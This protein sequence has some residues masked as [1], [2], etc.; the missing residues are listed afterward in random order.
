MKQMKFQNMK[1][2]ILMNKSGNSLMKKVNYQQLHKKQE[3]VQ[4]KVRSIIQFTRQKSIVKHKQSV[5]V[6]KRNKK[7]K[8]ELIDEGDF[9]HSAY[10]KKRKRT[11]R[12]LKI[13]SL[14]RIMKKPKRSIDEQQENN[15]NS[16]TGYL[17]TITENNQTNTNKNI[18]DFNEDLASEISP[19]FSDH[20]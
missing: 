19:N 6:V 12:F 3:I 10:I 5:L 9:A 8:Q 14:Q 13:R 16:Y 17:Q 18:S 7:K 4:K 20:I 2:M 15:P 11:I 1:K